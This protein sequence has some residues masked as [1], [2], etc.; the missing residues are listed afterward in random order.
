[1]SDDP[2]RAAERLA[3]HLAERGHAGHAKTMHGALALGAEHAVLHAL[4]N[5]CQTLLTAVEAFDPVT[6]GMAEELRLALDRRLGE[7]PP[8]DSPRASKGT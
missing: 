7:P 8:S 2:A 6:I 1:M 3:Q 4:R 5:V